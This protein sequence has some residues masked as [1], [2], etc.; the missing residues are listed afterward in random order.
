M[1][2]KKKNPKQG[3][4]ADHLDLL[5]KYPQTQIVEWL[6]ISSL[7]KSSFYDWKK[8]FKL[9]ID[10]DTQIKLE[11]RKIIKASK[12]R[13][14]YRR[15]SL[16]LRK[17]GYIVNHKKVL[18]MIREENLLCDKFNTQ[19]RKYS[20]YKGTVGKI[21]DNIVTHQFNVLAANKLWLTDVT[22]FRL[23]G[24]EKRLYLS[25]ILDAF[26][27]EIV[28]YNLSYRPDIRMT[29]TMLDQA[30]Q[31]RNIESNLIIHSDQ[32]FHYQHKSWMLKLTENGVTQSM[33]R[34]GNCLDNSP[35]ENFF[36]ILKQ[37]MFHGVTFNSYANLEKE[38]KSYIRWY[39]E[40][41][42][43]AKLNGL[44]PVEYRLQTA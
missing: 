19:S 30:L 2:E 35:M 25:P 10:P 14:G 9:M 12:E 20:S 24:Q 43:K 32:G 34:K 18:R 44:S 31:T 38:I 1:K 39:N 3:K 4:D 8:E 28:T 7:P 23:P 41:R 26:N 37:E 13:Y 5:E 17:L 29:N 36:G 11:I 22:E 6:K 16:T 27:G 40:E 33:S 21:A 15:V 42:I